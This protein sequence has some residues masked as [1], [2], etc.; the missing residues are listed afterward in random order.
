[1]DRFHRVIYPMPLP[2]MSPV[3]PLY[4]AFIVHPAC[5]VAAHR[6]KGRERDLMPEEMRLLKQMW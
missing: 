5:G 3:R 6:V 1:M 4:D 2:G